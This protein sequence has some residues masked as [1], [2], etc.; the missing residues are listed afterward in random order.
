M[1]DIER[2]KSFT[3]RG[4]SKALLPFCTAGCHK[5]RSP[6]QKFCSTLTIATICTSKARF[7]QRSARG[8]SAET[9]PYLWTWSSNIWIGTLKCIFW[10]ESLKSLKPEWFACLEIAAMSWKICTYDLAA[11]CSFCHFTT[12][13]NNYQHQHQHHHPHLLFGIIFSSPKSE[14]STTS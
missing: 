9:I 12:I 10:F 5:L 8:P 2:R 7:D 14:F 6:A 3:Y 13:V 11:I 1:H 4:E